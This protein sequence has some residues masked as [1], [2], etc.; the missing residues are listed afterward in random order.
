MI[1][2][3]RGGAGGE[4][5]AALRSAVAAP[6]PLEDVRPASRGL[7]AVL[8]VFAGFV[9]TRTCVRGTFDLVSYGFRLLLVLEGGEAADPPAYLTAIPDWKEGDEFLAASALRKF[10][11][12]AIGEPPSDDFHGLFVVEAVEG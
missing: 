11:I 9:H 4:L 5:N 3:L 7:V 10:R 2:R 1:A 12:V 6:A 8:A